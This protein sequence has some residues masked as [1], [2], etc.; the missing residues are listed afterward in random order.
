MW[1]S[2]Q[3][4][5][6]PSHFLLLYME[7]KS[8]TDLR[9]SSGRATLQY[10]PTNLPSRSS[11]GLAPH[12]WVRLT[13][14]LRPEKP[15]RTHCVSSWYGG[16]DMNQHAITM[17]SLFCLFLGF[18]WHS[19]NV[20]SHYGGIQHFPTL[21]RKRCGELWPGQDFFHF[22]AQKGIRDTHKTSPPTLFSP[23]FPSTSKSTVERSGLSSFSIPCPWCHCL[24]RNSKTVVSQ[25]GSWAEV[26]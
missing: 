24:C 1:V 19:Q 16:T 17:G 20:I 9:V 18:G 23:P 7:G 4:R 25:A 2:L 26:L 15:G 10:W 3:V 8:I 22:V 12:Y 6:C 21:L 14:L 11:Q 5:S 13:H